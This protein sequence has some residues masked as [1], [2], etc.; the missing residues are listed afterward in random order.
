MSTE[1]G[2]LEAAG[3]RVPAASPLSE[4]KL[5]LVENMEDL[6]TFKR[7]LGERRETPLAVDTETGGLDPWRVKLRLVQ[8]GDPN[9]GW[10]IPFEDWQGAIKEVLR[11]YEGRWIC[12]NLPFEQKFFKLHAGLTLP[13]ERCDDTMVE[14]ALLEPHKPKGLKPASER[15]VDPNAARGQDV[16]KDAMQKQGWTWETIPHS[17][18]P[19]WIYGALD[20]VLTARLWQWSHPRVLAECPE[21]YGLEMATLR[22]CHQMMVN[23][24]LLDV[25]YV[26]RSIQ[27][28]QEFST[29]AREWLQRVH[30]VTSPMSGAQISRAMATLGV[31][32]IAFTDGGAPR[33]DKETLTTYRGWAAQPRAQ[34]LASYVLSV[35]HADKMLGSY[36]ENFLEMMDGDHLIHCN[37]NTLAARTGRMSV[38]EP[39]L[40][41]LPRED[42]IIRGSFIPH[43]RKVLI[44]CDLSQV[45]ARLAA[46]FSQDPGLIE[47][48]RRADEDGDDFFCAVAGQ[49]FNEVITKADLR[50]Q[51]TKNVVYCSLYGG[52]V[53]KMAQTAGVPLA[54]M[55]PVKSAFDATYPGLQG[56]IQSITELGRR[57]NPPSIRSPLGRMLVADHGR[58]FTQLTN[59]LIQGHAAEYMKR[60][61]VDMDAAGLG[62]YL[63][64]LIHDEGILEAP[65]EEAEEVLRVMEQCMTDREK[66]LVPLT[67]DGKIMTERW[68]K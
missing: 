35:R 10:A 7:W 2:A 57:T 50:R 46:H 11:T 67:A 5:H 38:T 45:E 68:A 4:V 14:L 39:A 58:E 65:A 53:T 49:I 64:L 33:M 66:Y 12:H 19:Y 8:F 55:Q 42:K 26:Q 31:D 51:M 23:G 60:C 9:T 62:D 20:T 63:R 13:W 36:L 40:Q 16:L 3:T 25:P 56:L 52:G 47:A 37:I 6:F 17:F 54:Q 28:L 22:V 18:P 15:H 30:S 27:E 43:E 34:E 59:A 61:A 1:H 44:S 21:A 41:T 48:F 29:Q 24:M 32:P